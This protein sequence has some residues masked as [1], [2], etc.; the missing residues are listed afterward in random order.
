MDCE[1]EC[2]GYQLIGLEACLGCAGNP[3]KE[4]K[5]ERNYVFNNRYYNNIG[6]SDC[7]QELAVLVASDTAWYE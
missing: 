2:V 3:Y 7:K 4:K 5:G 6:L 1:K